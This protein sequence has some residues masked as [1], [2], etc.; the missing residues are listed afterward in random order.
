M[1]KTLKFNEIFSLSS[2][3]CH[4]Q[5]LFP[6]RLSVLS[7]LLDYLKRLHVRTQL[8]YNVITNYFNEAL[9]NLDI[10]PNAGPFDAVKSK[11]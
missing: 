1:A 4:S 9:C 6:D 8:D 3:Y 2:Q 11:V 10:A 7:Y 5:D